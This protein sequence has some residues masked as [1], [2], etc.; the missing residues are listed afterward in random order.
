M[1]LECEMCN[2]KRMVNNLISPQTDANSILNR[3]LMYNYSFNWWLVS[4]QSS[5]ETWDYTKLFSQVGN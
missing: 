3:I 2:L 1:P 4:E 5:F